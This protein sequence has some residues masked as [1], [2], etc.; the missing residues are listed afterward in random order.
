[1]FAALHFHPVLAL[2]MTPERWALLALVVAFGALAGG[3]A[4]RRNK[5]HDERRKLLMSISDYLKGIDLD[6][7]PALMDDLAARDI[8]GVFAEAR[9][10][11]AI[12]KSP[13]LLSVVE[14]KVALRLVERAS[15]KPESLAKIKAMVEKLTPPAPIIAAAAPLQLGTAAA[16]PAPPAAATTAAAPT[17]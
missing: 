6:H 16:P 5:V 17:A 11:E 3:F 2:N 4:F 10:V 15:K 7:I 9:K 1:M 12:F 13:E 8:T 14:L